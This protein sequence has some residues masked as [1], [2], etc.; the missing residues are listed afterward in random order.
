MASRAARMRSTD[1]W[2]STSPR[3]RSLVE[4]STESP[5]TPVATHAVTLSRSASGFTP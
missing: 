4:S 2:K 3:G 1:S 5:E